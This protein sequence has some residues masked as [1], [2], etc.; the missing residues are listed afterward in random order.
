MPYDNLTCC[1]IVLIILV[2]AIFLFIVYIIGKIMSRPSGQKPQTGFVNKKNYFSEDAQDSKEYYCEY[3]GDFLP[4]EL[5]LGYSKCR[6]CG[7]RNKIK[8]QY[9]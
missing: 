5:V 2:G 3:C 4:K 8:N 7:R 9:Y 6:S 1:S